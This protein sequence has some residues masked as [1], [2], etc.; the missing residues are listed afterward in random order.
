MAIVYQHRNKVT[1]EVFYVGIGIT[2]RRA[3]S[4]HN[5]NTYWKNI[6]KKYGYEID[7]LIEGCDY[8][9]AKN[10]EIGLI[11]A[12]GR[13]DIKTGS[14]VNMTDGGEGKLNWEVTNEIKN[15]ISK[16]LKGRKRPDLSEMR[17][18]FKQDKVEC[19]HCFNLIG[20]TNIKRHEKSCEK[21]PNKIHKKLSK[22]R[23]AYKKI[24]C[25]YCKKSFGS[26]VIDRHKKTCKA[27]K[28][29]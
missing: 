13:L 29:M 2:K 7:I 6:V 26:P 3:Y 22:P 11:N 14:L 8:E 4:R 25:E 19:K 18:G 15:K 28:V 12:Y 16:T 17:L 27:K 24:E 20:N 23:G 10:I 21:N 5:R 1:N 9:S